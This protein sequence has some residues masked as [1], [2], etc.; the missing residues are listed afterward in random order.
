MY[1][2]CISSQAKQSKSGL[3]IAAKTGWSKWLGFFSHE[4][5]K[6][7]LR[8][9]STGFHENKTISQYEK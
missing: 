1:I 5:L 8:S 3:A 7:P 2:C 9:E 6:K 4:F